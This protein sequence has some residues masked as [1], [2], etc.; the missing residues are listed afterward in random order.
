L[1]ADQADAGTEADVWQH[2]DFRGDSAVAG[3]LE[4]DRARVWREA[5]AAELARDGEAGETCRRRVARAIEAWRGDL[6]EEIWFEELLNL[7]PAAGPGA[8]G[9]DWAAALAEARA[10]FAAFCADHRQAPAAILGHDRF[11]LGRVVA[12]AT[13]A[14]LKDG[15]AGPPV[16]ALA[17]SLGLLESLPEGVTVRD[18]PAAGQP[19]RVAQLIQAGG[20]LWLRPAGAPDL[21]GS[22]LALLSTSNGLGEVGWPGER[23]ADPFWETGAPPP[24]ADA[25]GR[26]GYGAWVEF[27]VPGRDGA[28][29]TQRMRWIA[30]GSFWMGSPDDEPE[31]Y[32]DEDPRHEVTIREGYWLFDTACT[33]AL[34]AAVMGENPSRFQGLDRPVEGVSWNDARRFIETVNALKPGLDLVLPSET[35]WEY[36]CRAGTETPFSF[37][38]HITP[39]QVN[40]N[41]DYPYAGGVKGPY[42]GETVPVGSLSPN[43]WGLYEMHG[44][45]REWVQ[46]AWHDRY[47]GAPA[48]GCGWVSEAAGAARVIRGGSWLEVARCCRSAFRVRCAPDIRNHNLGFR[49]ARVQASES[50]RPAGAS[51]ARVAGAVARSGARPEGRLLR[52]GSAEAVTLPGAETTRPSPERG[53]PNTLF[54]TTDRQ[55]LTLRRAPR[56]AWARA[57]GRDRY[58]LWAELAVAPKAGGAPALQRLR[59]IPPGRFRMGSP[60]DEP[61][62]YDDEG[63]QQ[64]ITLATGYWLFDTPCTQALWAAL[65][66]DNPSR[67]QDPRRPVERVSWQRVHDEFLPALNARFQALQ[68]GDAGRFVLPSEAQWEYACRAGT[69]TALYTGPI[70]IL[71][72]MNAPAL[73]AIAWYGGNSGHNYDLDEGEDSTALWWEGKDKQYPH[74]KVGTRQVKGKD[75]NPWGLYDMLGNVQEWTEDAWQDSHA[76]AD[77]AG[78]PREGEAGAF[79]VVR[80]GS[81]IHSARICR[82]AFRFRSSPDFRSN[83]LGFRCARVQA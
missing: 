56:P 6:P 29:V 49:C 69:E 46:D 21:P 71:G 80:G 82:S 13:G 78:R 40:Y 30:P 57:M 66:G 64:T 63:P 33:Q 38:A 1:P 36:A 75:A 4:P 39:E 51:G 26:D 70:D 54:V 24:W 52:L 20:G 61:G 32:E 47:R 79:R 53:G 68:A 65:L 35:Q 34:W 9:G 7:A 81:W 22:P 14:L 59:W 19:E 48:D 23:G 55:R 27:S 60:D 41:G 15:E 42:R 74:A 5:F 73:N 50:G 18:V 25:W 10:Y 11:W 72:D 37:G 44:N 43:A 2:P 76:G 67:F 12:R 45:V 77:P 17:G 31:R 58:G 62:R 3:C 83:F 8:D 28:S 16:L